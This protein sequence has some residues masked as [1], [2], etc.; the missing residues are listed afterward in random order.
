M[1]TGAQPW[2]NEDIERV[3]AKWPA[4]SEVKSK[5]RAMM[6]EAVAI[7]EERPSTLADARLGRELVARLSTVVGDTGKSESAIEALD[8]LLTEHRQHVATS[9]HERG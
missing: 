8:R 3:L 5:A 6:D 1:T 7:A 9:V 4:G 2:S